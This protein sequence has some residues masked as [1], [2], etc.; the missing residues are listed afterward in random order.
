VLKNG[1]E[2]GRNFFCKISASALIDEVNDED[3]GEKGGDEDESEREGDGLIRFKD[4]GE[5]EREVMPH[6][7]GGS[8]VCTD[9]E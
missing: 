4:G 5:C 9:A 1:V 7:N 2:E 3:E 8:T 6:A